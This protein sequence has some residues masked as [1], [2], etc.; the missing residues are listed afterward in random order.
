MYAMHT[1][2][3]TCTHMYIHTQKFYL[4]YLSNEYGYTFIHVVVLPHHCFHH[5]QQPSVCN[6]PIQYLVFLILYSQVYIYST[7]T[8]H[9]LIHCGLLITCECMSLYRVQQP[10]LEYRIPYN[11]EAVTTCTCTCGCLEQHLYGCLY[12]RMHDMIVTVTSVKHLYSTLAPVYNIIAS[13]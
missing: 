10:Q 3:H 9:A 1:C 2:V 12:F 8:Y 13:L 11:L 7:C 6:I 4:R 5:D